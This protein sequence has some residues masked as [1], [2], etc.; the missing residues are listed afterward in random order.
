VRRATLTIGTE[1]ASLRTTCAIGRHWWGCSAAS[2]RIEV[3]T[4]GH[5]ATQTVLV[6]DELLCSN[7]FFVIVSNPLIVPCD[8]LH[9]RVLH[10]DWSQI[11]IT[12]QVFDLIERQDASGI[13]AGARSVGSTEATARCVAGCIAKCIATTVPREAKLTVF[14]FDELQSR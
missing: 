8:G 14:R 3:N 9:Q 7:G 12:D 13:G 1:C 6:G 11:P 4:P 10:V 5:G 2:A